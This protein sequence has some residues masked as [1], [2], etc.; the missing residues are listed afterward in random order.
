MP[1]GLHEPMKEQCVCVCV[2]VCVQEWDGSRFTFVQDKV[3]A[4][5]ASGPVIASQGTQPPV[6]R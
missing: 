1:R 3:E 5:Q 4:G 6:A 2:C